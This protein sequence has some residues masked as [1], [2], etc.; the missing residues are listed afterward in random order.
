[1]SRSRDG[2]GCRYHPDPLEGQSPY[3]T[4]TDEQREMVNQAINGHDTV[5]RTRDE[6]ISSDSSTCYYLPYKDP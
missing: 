4:P 2:L 5:T 1:M 6:V 3:W